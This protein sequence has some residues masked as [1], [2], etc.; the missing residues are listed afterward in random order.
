MLGAGPT[1]EG[2]WNTQ[3]FANVLALSTLYGDNMSCV[4]ACYG[5][6][7]SPFGQKHQIMQL[8]SNT[9]TQIFITWVFSVHPVGLKAN[10]AKVFFSSLEENTYYDQ[11]K[12]KKLQFNFPQF[13]WW[14][15]TSAEKH[16][17]VHKKFSNHLQHTELL[18]HLN[19][20]VLSTNTYPF[21]EWMHMYS[22]IWK[23]LTNTEYWRPVKNTILS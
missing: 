2:V 13:H 15:L 9:P 4:A 23:L 19:E 3:L 21:N 14:T 20:Y 12:F 1:H 10:T 17:N 7:L 5:D 6:V 22:T 18:C 8:K 11:L 16:Q